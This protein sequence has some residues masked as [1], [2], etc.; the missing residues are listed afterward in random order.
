MALRTYEH[1][2]RRANI[3]HQ[4]FKGLHIGYIDFPAAA[5]CIEYNAAR[6]VFLPASFDEN[7][8]LSLS[9]T[10]ASQQCCIWSNGRIDASSFDFE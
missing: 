3:A 9:A 8:D 2:A 10:N 1:A 5:L 4:T 7:V 6:E